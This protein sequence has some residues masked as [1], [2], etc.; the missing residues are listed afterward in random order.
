MVNR[1]RDKKTKTKQKQKQKQK[2]Y[3][4]K[5]EKQNK[6]KNRNK[7]RKQNKRQL[8]NIS[9][10][11]V[12]TLYERMSI[13]HCAFLAKTKTGYFNFYKSVFKDH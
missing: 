11:L 5:K 8:R 6:N 1:L 7:N 10:V 13:S 2:Q 9:S 12:N 3:K 4:T